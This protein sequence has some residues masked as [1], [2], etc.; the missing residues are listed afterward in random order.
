MSTSIKDTD[1]NEINSELE[2]MMDLKT[3]NKILIALKP[4]EKLLNE[5]YIKVVGIEQKVIVHNNYENRIRTLETNQWKIT[6]IYTG[7]LAVMA[8]IFSLLK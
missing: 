8:V 1:G 2:E 3:E 5:T 6:G 4:L 7:I